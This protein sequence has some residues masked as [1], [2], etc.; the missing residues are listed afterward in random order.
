MKYF[1]PA[2]IFFIASFAL[3]AQQIK[4]TP[5]I[6]E[7]HVVTDLSDF[8]AELELPGKISNN[9]DN[10]IEIKWLQTLWDQPFEWQAEIA[11][12]DNYYLADENGYTDNEYVMPLLLQ[13]GETIDLSIYIYPNGRA[14]TA[15]Y[16]I[17]VVDAADHSKVLETIVYYIS[18]SHKVE[19]EAVTIR[20][21]KVFP[22]PARDYFEITPNQLISKITLY[23]SIGQRVKT[24]TAERGKK[25]DVTTIPNG[26]YLAELSDANG[27]TL[28]TVRLLKR[29]PKA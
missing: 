26:L 23:N 21:V 7:Q 13:P 25:Y 8:S 1:L 10:P 29:T 17:D 27:K 19:V 24:Y 2:F 28:K 16:A 20:N 14:G 22:N 9:T 3:S 6:V 5:E 11:D 4:A 15:T 18:V 12:R